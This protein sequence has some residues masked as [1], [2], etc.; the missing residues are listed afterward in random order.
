MEVYFECIQHA[1]EYENFILEYNCLSSISLQIDQIATFHPKMYLFFRYFFV[2]IVVIFYLTE[3]SEQLRIKY[4]N[5]TMD[6]IVSRAGNRQ[7]LDARKQKIKNCKLSDLWKT[8]WKTPVGN[9]SSQFKSKAVEQNP[10][11]GPSSSKVT[12]DNNVRKSNENN[13]EEMIRTIMD[14]LPHLGDGKVLF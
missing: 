10:R 3:N 7:S 4:I 1:L 14:T 12:T 5:A 8:V 13:V 6:S 11:M 2:L 9:A